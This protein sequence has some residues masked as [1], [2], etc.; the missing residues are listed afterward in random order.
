METSIYIV[1]GIIK[2]YPPFLE[3]F[4]TDI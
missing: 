3:S 2:M 4:L 1:A